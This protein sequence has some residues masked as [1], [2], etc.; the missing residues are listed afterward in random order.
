MSEESKKKN[1]HKD[2]LKT[3]L[4]HCSP[5]LNLKSSR[6]SRRLSDSNDQR[7]NRPQIKAFPID[8]KGDIET[9]KILQ[10]I[11]KHIEYNSSADIA[12]DTAF[13]GAVTQGFGYF[14]ITTGYSSPDSFNQE[15]YYRKV[16]NPFSVYF[17]PQ[18]IEPDGSDAEDAHIFEEM[19]K[20][21]FMRA[22]PNAELSKMESW[23]STGDSEEWYTKDTVR[24]AEYFYKH[25]EDTTLYLLA[26]G[27]SV[28]KEDFVEGMNA[29][30]ERPTQKC[31]V[32][33]IKHNGSEVLEETEWL[34]KW[35]P[36]IPVYGDR[37]NV[38]GKVILEGIVRNAKDSLRMVNYYTSNEAEAIALAPKA[39]FIISEGQVEGYEK[40]WKQANRTSL[41]YLTYKSENVNGVLAPPPTRNNFE[42][43]VQAIT[44]AKMQAS[45]DIKAV[46]GIYDSS[47]GA[48]SNE[49]SG[50]A[51]RG[52]QAQAQTSNFHFID[53]LTR[54]IKHAG[55]ILID[56]IPKVYKGPQAVRIL[57]EDGEQEIV[58]I[59]AMFNRNGKPVYYDLGV[60]TYDVVVETGPS[61]AT[62]RQ[63]AAQ[64][65]MDFA[66][67]VPAQASLVT[68]L[69]LKNMDV[70]GA[71]EMAERIKKTLPPNLLDDKGQADIPPQAQAMMQQQDQ[72]I[73]QQQAQ[74]AQANELLKNKTLE[75][76]SKKQIEVEKLMSQE[77][78]KQADLEL[79]YVKL[80]KDLAPEQ[81]FQVIISELAKINARQEQFEH[82]L[83]EFVPQGNVT[84]QNQ[85]PTDGFSSGQNP[86][87]L[88]P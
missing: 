12:L 84:Q 83:N 30:D 9:A 19:S 80:E 60:G 75:L 13:E 11:I 49:T 34:G 85:M 50:V 16:D 64:F 55:R 62:K 57:G 59:N 68:D 38:N 8:D 66:K 72:M 2:I 82:N 54:S 28:Y 33:W 47:L 41:A 21:E 65:L 56:L 43:A 5:A 1:N 77:R 24:V 32:K 3:S 23:T 76:E 10:G 51:I 39:P 63:E 81:A 22:Y 42:P 26:D 58:T 78:M 14:R 48:R 45:D 36:I 29:I 69:I 53:N 17:D 25:Y 74:L 73:Q 40:F 15:I 7:Q 71:S 18:S 20:D 4:G 27:S 87:E 35:I 67:T 44:S 88:Q 6:A 79:E 52:R 46:T 37:I 31:T 70:P 86:M 61:Y